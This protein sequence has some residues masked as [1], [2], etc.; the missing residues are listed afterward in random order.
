MAIATV[1]FVRA[2][3]VDE[4]RQKAC[5][6][7]SGEGQ[8]IALFMDGGQVYAVDNRCPHMGFPLSKGSVR[9]GILTY[10]WHHA[11]FDMGSGGTFDPGLMTC[12]S[13]PLG[14]TMG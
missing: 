13:F 6:V 2:G 11:R 8:T 7:V 1:G 4:L 9:N 12:A 14:S 10:H 3:T 5:L